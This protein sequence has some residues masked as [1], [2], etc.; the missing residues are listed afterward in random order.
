MTRLTAALL[1][2]CTA[3]AA[4]GGGGPAEPPVP[5]DPNDAASVVEAARACN[6]A[7]F[8]DWPAADVGRP[9]FSENMSALDRNTLIS[10]LYIERMSTE[11]CVY[12]L[13]SGLHIQVNRAVEEGVSIEPGQL[14]R[15]DYEGTLPNGR[16]FDSSY[17]RGRPLCMSS[18]DVIPGW[19]EALSLMRAGEEWEIFI[20]PALGYREF[21]SPPAVPPNMALRFRME[22]LAAPESC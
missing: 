17:A 13:P 16:M 14:F 22:L 20:P 2:S 6:P 1:M 11:P 8:E 7:D 18:G 4:C 12:A 15:A 19:T 5:A 21:G 3:L 9:E 10:E